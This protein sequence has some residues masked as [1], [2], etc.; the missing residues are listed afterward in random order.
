M[1]LFY[2]RVE[3]FATT[4][5]AMK[6]A[7]IAHGALIFTILLITAFYFAGISEVPFHPDESTQLFMSADLEQLFTRPEKLFWHPDWEQDSHQKYRA[8]DAPLTRYLIGVGR[9]AA[10][11]DAPSVD[12]NWS[13]NWRANQENGAIPDP[14]LL[15]AARLAVAA[16]FPFS[17]YFTFKTAETLGGRFCGWLSLA[18]L[19]G[20]AL[21]L[22][23]TR[24]A[25][26]EGALTFGVTFTLWALTRFNRSPWLLAIPIALAF[27]AKQSAGAL[28]AVGLLAIW[29][30]ATDST[31]PAMVRLRQS[32]A[33]FATFAG[34]T[35]LLN[36]FFWSN[37]LGA[38]AASLHASQ[39][40]LRRQIETMSVVQPEL[41]PTAVLKHL[42]AIWTQL[43]LAPPAIAEVGNYLQETQPAAVQY[44]FSPLNS[45]LRGVVGGGIMM[46]LSFSGFA[47]ALYQIVRYPRQPKRLLILLCSATLLE[48]LLLSWIP[49]VF[50]R[51]TLPLV[52]FTTIWTAYCLNQIR[53]EIPF[54][55]FLRFAAEKFAGNLQTTNRAISIDDRPGGFYKE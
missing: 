2:R 13:L 33:Y 12:W 54:K 51:Y 50:Q 15:L 49:L 7:L 10:G 4:F 31:R 26:A 48:T 17:L 3:Q 11:L 36:P 5:P 52:P 32:L 42:G 1:T 18:L 30:P 19:A 29:W 9:L 24:R 47:F 39:D 37:P 23:H 16:L 44:F 8:V 38:G 41:A 55:P 53:Q 25:M 6:K 28:L 34:I 20:N 27:N 40:L 43:F 45:L 14:S 35:L 46:W 22:L 21:I